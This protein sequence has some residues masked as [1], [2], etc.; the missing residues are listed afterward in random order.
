MLFPAAY[1]YLLYIALIGHACLSII[2]IIVS[3]M[4]K[5]ERAKYLPIL[6]GVN[7]SIFI[8]SILAGSIYL[9]YDRLLDSIAFI[10]YTIIIC[11]VFAIEIPGYILLS[12]YDDKLIEILNQFRKNIIS[13]NYDFANLEGLREAFELH[14]KQFARTPI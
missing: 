12:R 10:G 5:N 1:D 9:N 14:K 7:L 11:Y 2:L 8:G 6:F 13:L 4:S 3:V